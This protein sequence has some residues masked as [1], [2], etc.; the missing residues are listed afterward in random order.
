MTP[1]QNKAIRGRWRSMLDRCQ[2]PNSAA[3]SNYGGRGIKVCDRWQS[4]EAFFA[5]TG[6]PAPGLTLDRIDN[7]G[8]Y[9]PENC[10]WATRAE[11]RANQSTCH[12][13][14]YQGERRLLRHWAELKGLSEKT[15]L[16]RM[17]RGWTLEAAME[18]P[19]NSVDRQN[20]LRGNATRW[21]QEACR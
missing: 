16:G 5:D 1:Q 14:E 2:N 8:P 15:L 17:R 12:Y 4:F 10:R 20:A 9:S 11:Q 3:W 18:T 6:V 19:I 13:V 21:S 7:D